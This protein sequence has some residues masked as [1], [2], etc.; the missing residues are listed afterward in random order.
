MVNGLRLNCTFRSS[1]IYIKKPP[2]QG[3][4]GSLGGITNYI[5]TLKN[6]DQKSLESNQNPLNLSPPDLQMILKL[7]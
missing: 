5:H 4:I 2:H 3:A 1:F 7:I 6:V